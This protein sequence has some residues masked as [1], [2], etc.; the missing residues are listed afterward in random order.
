MYWLQ[1]SDH[2]DWPHVQYFDSP[3]D[4]SHQLATV[5]FE[6]ISEGM[7]REMQLKKVHLYTAWCD[8]IRRI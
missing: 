4:L 2:Y 6:A 5:N 8:F 1:L 3:E 7:R